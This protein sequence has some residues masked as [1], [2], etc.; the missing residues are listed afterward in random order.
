MHARKGLF[1]HLAIWKVFC[2][3]WFNDKEESEGVTHPQ[4]FADGTSLVT[5]ALVATAVGYLHCLMS[6]PLNPECQIECAIDE[7]KTG[8][9]KPITFSVKAYE[10]VFNRH[11]QTL[12]NWQA[13]SVRTG[14][15]VTTLVQSELLAY[16]RYVHKYCIT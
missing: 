3:V 10:P 14:S 6:D 1:R 16:A 15:N 11:L 12:R 2:K 4:Y 13:F 8:E 9:Y 5:M 7:F